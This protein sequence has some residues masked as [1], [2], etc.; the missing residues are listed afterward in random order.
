MITNYPTYSLL[1]HIHQMISDAEER[2]DSP[3]TFVADS[4][5]FFWCWIGYLDL[6]EKLVALIG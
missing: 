2:K 1:I 4:S 3:E 6:G 5:S